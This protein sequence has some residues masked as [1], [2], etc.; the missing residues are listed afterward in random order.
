[1]ERSGFWPL[2]A[3][4]VSIRYNKP[5]CCDVCYTDQGTDALLRA[6]QAI[7]IYSHLTAAKAMTASVVSHTA[8]RLMMNARKLTPHRGHSGDSAPT[9]SLHAGHF[10]KTMSHLL[11]LSVFWPKVDIATC[12]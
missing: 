11:R 2:P 6:D 4:S 1:M 12:W 5:A 7:F 3:S 10:R 8:Y 9:V